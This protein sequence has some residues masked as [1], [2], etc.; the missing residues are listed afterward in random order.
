MD[1]FGRTIEAPKIYHGPAG[2]IDI[3]WKHPKYRILINIP[4]DPNVPATFYGDDYKLE[5]IE[6]KFDPNKL[7]MKVLHT[8]TDL[9]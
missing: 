8:I 6:G 5:Q 2:S 1:E 7:N 4:E 3:L 9:E